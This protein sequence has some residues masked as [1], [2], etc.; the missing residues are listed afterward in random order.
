MLPCKAR[1]AISAVSCPT[2]GWAGS[3]TGPSLF[4]GPAGTCQVPDC[5]LR[6]DSKT[7]TSAGPQGTAVLGKVRTLPLSIFSPSSRPAQDPALTRGIRG[8]LRT[9]SQEFTTLFHPLPPGIHTATQAGD[10]SE[11]LELPPPQEDSLEPGWEEI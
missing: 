9:V 7:E 10:S 6:Y 5:R 8:K 11:G 1:D 4:E 3:G 2:M